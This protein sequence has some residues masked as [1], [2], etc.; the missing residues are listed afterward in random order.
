[1]PQNGQSPSLGTNRL[2]HIPAR[3][4]DRVAQ[5]RRSA[6][7]TSAERSS[8]S[9]W[10]AVVPDSTAHAVHRTIDQP[11]TRCL[12]GH[13]SRSLPGGADRASARSPG[14]AGRGPRRGNR[15]GWTA[16]RIRS[17]SARD[18]VRHRWHCLPMSGIVKVPRPK[19][20]KD[21]APATPAAWT[22]P[23]VPLVVRQPTKAVAA[24][25]PSST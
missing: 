12:P 16:Q 21:C 9:T 8:P 20:Q 7:T 23:S 19:S 18:R 5:F 15:T 10:P 4:G 3:R 13:C 14:H 17:N 22:I 1:M 11:D 6:C 24:D 2:D 25:P